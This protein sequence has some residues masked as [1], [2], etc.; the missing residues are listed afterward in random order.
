MLNIG[1]T[2]D[3]FQISSQKLDCDK[4]KDNGNEIVS[5]LNGGMNETGGDG[6]SNA[7]SLSKGSR[8]KGTSFLWE[9]SDSD[10]GKMCQELASTPAGQN[11][12]N[13]FQCQGPGT[14]GIPRN[15][16]EYSSNSD[17]NYMGIPCING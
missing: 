12:I 1:G 9:N 11:E 16:P 14:R 4:V 5:A 13:H 3:N 15:F 8:C 6:Y 10:Y 17:V 2:T 7:F